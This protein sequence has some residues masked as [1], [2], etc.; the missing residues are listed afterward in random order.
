MSPGPSYPVPNFQAKYHSADV[1][2]RTMQSQ[3]PIS[4][5]SCESVM[6]Q[7]IIGGQRPCRLKSLT[8]FCQR[9]LDAIQS[10]QVCICKSFSNHEIDN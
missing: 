8:T 9:Y 2:L 3:H 4:T 6:N 1:T 7:V 10:G 5:I